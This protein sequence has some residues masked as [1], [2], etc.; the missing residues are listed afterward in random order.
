MR[1]RQCNKQTW[2]V[3]IVPAAPFLL[4]SP[5]NPATALEP[6]RNPR[7]L[8]RTARR[9]PHRVGDVITH[10]NGRSIADKSRGD[11]RQMLATAGDEFSLAIERAGEVQHLSSGMTQ[12]GEGEVS[13]STPWQR[14]TSWCCSS[15]LLVALHSSLH[16]LTCTPLVWGSCS[17][18]PACDVDSVGPLTQ[19]AFNMHTN[20]HTHRTLSLR[21]AIQ[22][23]HQ[24]PYPLHPLSSFCNT[25]C[26]PTTIPTTPLSSFCNTRGSASRSSLVAPL[27]TVRRLCLSR[28][29]LWELVLGCALV[30]SSLLSTGC[31][32]SDA[33]TS[34]SS[35]PSR[36]R[37]GARALR[38]WCAVQCALFLSH[39]VFATLTRAVSRSLCMVL[40][41][42][43]GACLFVRFGGFSPTV[44]LI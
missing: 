8:T 36:Y 32:W 11:A 37:L 20:N 6:H 12:S 41:T 21:S 28:R 44:A 27:A 13:R 42:A 2:C 24:Q 38:W 1:E 35:R 16:L 25:T 34:T 19:P 23:A 18:Q 31:R 40:C 7:A 29:G 33:H 10:V 9:T 5:W 17:S 3:A 14:R 15:V 43:L 30:T 39:M 4:A 22:H 26:T